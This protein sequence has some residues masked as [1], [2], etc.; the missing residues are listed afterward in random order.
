MFFPNLVTHGARQ[1]SDNQQAGR[2]LSVPNAPGLAEPSIRNRSG[3]DSIW[4]RFGGGG[5]G[6]SVRPTSDLDE[7]A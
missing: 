3:F 7:P 4:P 6:A 5:G 2:P 1:S